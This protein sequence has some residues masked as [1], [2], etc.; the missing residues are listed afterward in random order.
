MVCFGDEGSCAPD[1]LLAKQALYYLSYVP[2]YFGLPKGMCAP[3]DGMKV[4]LPT[5]ERWG[6]VLVT[7]TEIESVILAL[8]G[9]CPNQLD[10]EVMNFGG[11]SK[12]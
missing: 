10:D 7:S 4:R 2:V 1:I 3:V 9:P 8:R 6:A 11:D 12:S 5:T